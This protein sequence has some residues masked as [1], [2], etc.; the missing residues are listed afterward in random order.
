MSGLFKIV[1]IILFFIVLTS[2]GFALFYL[3]S[4]KKDSHR[5]VS[6]LTLRVILSFL[7]LGLLLIGFFNGLIQPNIS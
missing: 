1:F 4:N 6:A 3:S 5:M 7:L 2:L